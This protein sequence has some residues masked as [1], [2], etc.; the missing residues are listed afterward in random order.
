MDDGS[1][2]PPWL[3]DLDREGGGLLGLCNRLLSQGA[4]LA[5]PHMAARCP[6]RSAH[7]RLDAAG[8]GT[9]EA[10]RLWISTPRAAALPGGGQALRF[11]VSAACDRGDRL[12]CVRLLRPDGFQAPGGLQLREPHGLRRAW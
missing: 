8:G 2:L 10:R 12:R 6:Y 1:G 5:I 9:P 4:D 11:C 3:P 7:G